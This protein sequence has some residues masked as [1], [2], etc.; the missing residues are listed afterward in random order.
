[1]SSEVQ[2]G[3]GKC[4]SRQSTKQEHRS[5]VRPMGRDSVLVGVARVEHDVSF[6]ND[7]L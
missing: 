1:M 2:I 7:A 3:L 6:A 5:E 4:L